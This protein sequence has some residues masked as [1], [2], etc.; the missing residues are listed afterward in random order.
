MGLEAS[1][2]MISHLAMNPLVLENPL[3]VLEL[4]R[5]WHKTLLVLEGL[6]LG[7]ALAPCSHSAVEVEFG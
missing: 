2:T 7:I 6:S 4:E 1:P 3:A 5:C